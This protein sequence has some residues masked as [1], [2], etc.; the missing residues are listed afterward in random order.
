MRHI[1][2]GDRD[3]RGR[4]KDTTRQGYRH[5]KIRTETGE[6]RDSGYSRG[7]RDRNQKR[8]GDRKRQG[9]S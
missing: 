1:D 2:K 9:L 8:Q 7:D 5:R 4:D 3:K 6:I